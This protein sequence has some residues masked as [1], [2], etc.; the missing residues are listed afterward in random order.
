MG[1][2]IAGLLVALTVSMEAATNVKVT[3]ISEPWLAPSEFRL[4]NSSA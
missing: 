2:L 4:R 3:V 1:K